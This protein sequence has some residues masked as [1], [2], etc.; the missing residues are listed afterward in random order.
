MKV[1][2]AIRSV[3]NDDEKEKAKTVNPSCCCL[4]VSDSFVTLWTVAHQC[5]LSLGFPRQEYW[6][7]LP[8][9][10]SEDFSNPETEPEST[11]LAGRSFTTE[12]P[13]KPLT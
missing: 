9:P 12:P 6:S 8:F 7:G 1:L 10:S 11:A 3:C 13:G 5:P 4:V 2:L